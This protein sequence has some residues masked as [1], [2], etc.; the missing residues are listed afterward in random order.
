MAP[1]VDLGG[2]VV[3]NPSRQARLEDRVAKL[4][5]EYGNLAVDLEIER[6]QKAQA[7][8]EA[9]SSGLSA[10]A[11]SNYTFIDTVQ[12]SV[13]ATTTLQAIKALEAEITFLYFAIE[14]GF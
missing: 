1:S 7:M 10:A 14:H 3:A 8:G 5:E 12:Q 6:R 4:T 11:T 9:S 13:N 2:P